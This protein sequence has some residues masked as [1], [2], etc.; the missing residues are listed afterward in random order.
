MG[1]VPLFIA[2]HV[3]S[4]MLIHTKVFFLQETQVVI[5][6]ILCLINVSVYASYL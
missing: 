2:I 4:C 1:R 5:T 3:M 6:L